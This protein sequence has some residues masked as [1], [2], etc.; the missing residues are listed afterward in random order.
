[1]R[2]IVKQYTIAAPLREVYLALTNTRTMEQWSGSTVVM[3]LKDGGTFELWDG[4]IHGFNRKLTENCIIQDWKEE[5]WKEFSQVTFRL[6][7]TNRSTQLELVHE[8]VPDESSAS[9]DKG[10]DEYYLGPLKALLES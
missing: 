10:W 2:T 1:M 4:T 9:I 3:E 8:H 6:F 5:S 7:E